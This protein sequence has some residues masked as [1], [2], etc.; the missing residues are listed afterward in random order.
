M[1]HELTHVWQYVTVG[2]IYLPQAAPDS[3]GE[4]YDY[5]G[6]ADLRAKMAAG[7]GFDAYNR[8]QQGKI[9]EDYFVLR[10]QARAYRSRRRLCFSVDA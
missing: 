8:E 9:V 2:L 5:G 1:I 10:G 6:V 3:L 7:E 4:N